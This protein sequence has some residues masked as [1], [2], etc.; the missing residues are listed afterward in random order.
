MRTDF[1]QILL[2]LRE[3]EGDCKI[4]IRLGKTGSGKTTLQNEVNVLPLLLD[5]QEVYCCYWLNYNGDNLHYFRPKDFKAVS[6]LRNCVIVFDE[7]RRSFEPRDFKNESEEFRSFVELQR[8][9]HNEII[10]NTQDIS[11]VS[12][13][14]G[15]QTHYWSQVD[16]IKQSFLMRF[17]DKV[18]QREKIIIMEDYL[19]YQ[20]LK[21]MSMGYELGEDV[22]LEAEWKAFKF[23]RE[24]L[25]HRE[26][27]EF[28]LEL[29][30]RYC[31]KCKSRQGAQILKE[32][33]DKVCS[34]RVDENGRKHFFL[35]EEEFCPKH[36][37]IPLQIRESGMFDSDYE[38]E[39]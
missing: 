1:K 32:D 5:G 4:T 38:P 37:K 15:I 9:R 16:L 35:L 24:H 7:V 39:D 23:T 27:D 8:H 14:I 10:A 33:T 13:T 28:K 36:S 2:E 18:F 30:H 6:R 12:K 11:L 20:E 25:L 29:V 17:I 26:L 19:T 22:A 21:K 34:F 31:P 3:E